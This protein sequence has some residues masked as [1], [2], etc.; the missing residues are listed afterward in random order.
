MKVE[1]RMRT[2]R[3]VQVFILP[4]IL[5]MCAIIAGGKTA[6]ANM[7]TTYTGCSQWRIPINPWN[8]N[9]I[10]PNSSQRYAN[11]GGVDMSCADLSG[12]DFYGVVLVNNRF[13][14]SNLSNTNWGG[15][16]YRGIYFLNVDVTGSNLLSHGT[17]DLSYGKSVYIPTTTTTTT[18]TTTT[19]TTT[20]PPTT[21]TT[22]TTS[23][24][25]PSIKTCISSG[26]TFWTT[27]SNGP[28][29]SAYK[30]VEESNW[31]S[32]SDFQ[33]K[34][35]APVYIITSMSTDCSIFNFT[36]CG[37]GGPCA[38]EPTTTT[39]TAP[40]TTAP[41]TTTTLPRW[42][43]YCIPYNAYTWYQQT[44]DSSYQTY[45][46]S[47]VHPV[48]NGGC[49]SL[50]TTPQTTTTTAAPTC[51]PTTDKLHIWE[52]LGKVTNYGGQY[53]SGGSGFTTDYTRRCTVGPIQSVLIRTSNGTTSQTSIN[54]EIYFPKETSNCWEI[55]RVSQYGQ[56]AWSNKVCY[57]APRQC[58]PKK[59]KLISFW[60]GHD[61]GNPVEVQ[62]SNKGVY[63]YDSSRECNVGE[64]R[65]VL[66]RTNNGTKTKLGKITDFGH[67]FEPN[68]SNC[69]EIALVAE[70]GQ[71]PWSNKICHTYVAPPPK[72]WESYTSK[73]VYKKTDI[74][75]GAICSDGSRSTAT[76][77][78]ACS[79]HGG[80][81][82]WLTQTQTTSSIIQTRTTTPN[83]VWG[84][85][86]W[87][88]TG[89]CYGCTSTITGRP[90]TNLVSGYW[91]GGTW[92]NSYWRS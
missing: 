54:F 13:D 25:A 30:K 15:T 73:T 7:S 58:L 87:G 48:P 22:T 64:Y 67:I 88:N 68:S 62:W 63:G 47:A 18:S 42:R 65:G 34:T 55:A 59:D 57:K 90:K 4:L 85:T 89:N 14:N 52:S 82:T 41:S 53:D 16:S 38:G 84:N 61:N 29:N 79:W 45:P 40:S 69:W 71:S 91:R 6:Q 83:T 32:M 81:A 50:N 66:I 36:S 33:R 46:A 60:W 70:Y 72:S 20:L 12:I 26:Y 43:T 28:F 35:M 10:L 11:L 75:T 21:T 27:Q 92:V 37:Y 78:G 19:T 2:K 76:G 56:S 86:G 5:I 24:V 9:Q 8:G 1:Y 80:V 17:W 23:T 39:T 31:L 44:L 49:S 51:P 74:R 77:S 3:L